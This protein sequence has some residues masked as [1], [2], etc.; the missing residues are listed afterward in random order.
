MIGGV[1]DAT[2][3]GNQITG[4]RDA[5]IV[6]EANGANTLT[7]VTVTGNTIKSQ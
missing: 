6:L 5:G 2:V 1:T 4:S 3:T 7:D